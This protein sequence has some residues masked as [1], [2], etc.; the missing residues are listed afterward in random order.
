MITFFFISLIIFLITSII[1]K[2]NSPKNVFFDSDYV[3]DFVAITWGVFGVIVITYIVLF[4][5]I[6]L[7]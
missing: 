6:F 4:I 2:K 5:F 1:I 3:S 7:P